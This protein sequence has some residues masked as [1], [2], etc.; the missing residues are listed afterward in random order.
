M[1]SNFKCEKCEQTFS[2]KQCLQGHITRNAC[3]IPTVFCKYC[4]SG[5]TTETSMYRHM[6]KSCKVK[7]E[8]EEKQLETNRLEKLENENKELKNENKIILNRLVDLENEIKKDKPA[9][10]YVN[11]GNVNN[12]VN[13]VNN[14]TLVKHGNEDISKLGRGNLLKIYARGFYAPYALIND[15][16]FNANH[17]EYHNVYISNMSN[18]Y[19]IAYD[20]KNWQLIPKN[21]LIDSIYN[22]KKNYIEENFED[23]V[24]SLTKSQ[25]NALNRW[26]DEDEDS[27]KIKEIKNMIKLSLYNN[28][29]VVMKT[30]ALLTNSEVINTTNN[31]KKIKSIKTIKHG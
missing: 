20:G 30:M 26:L 7:K 25:K 5:F 19:A 21:D 17:P 8:T 28:R 27:N 4:K 2:T 14:I 16:H 15:V 13:C 12:I 23:F 1:G 24:D 11:F 3:K 31:V 18:K 22:D 29:E 9:T 6:R 10:N